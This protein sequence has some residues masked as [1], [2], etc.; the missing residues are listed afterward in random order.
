MDNYEILGISKDTSM[1]EVK[2]AYEERLYEI[3]NEVVN[4]KNAKAFKKVLKYAYEDIN[5]KSSIEDTLVMTKEDFRNAMKQAG[6]KDI[7]EEDDYYEDDCDEYTE[8]DYNYYYGED[9]S[10]N[11]EE[12]SYEDE[13]DYRI[14]EVPRQRRSSRYSKK[15]KHKNKKKAK[16]NNTRT[17]EYDR[18]RSEI[19][20]DEEDIE[21]NKM[22]WLIKFPLSVLAIPFIVVLAI[23]LFI[24]DILNVIL[25]IIAK[26]LIFASVVGG[27][28]YGLAVYKE[29]L[30][31]D[32]RA[33]VICGV[34]FILSLIVP[35]VLE[36]I[37][38]PLEILNNKLK[39]FVF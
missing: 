17:R 35:P 30:P 23:I 9:N 4:R 36:V 31:L 7:D 3:D 33:F 24:C 11:Q 8:E 6:F 39:A 16:K 29:M 18:R 38:K 27:V 34:V 2:A 32:N 28:A 25:S 14:N 10:D 20:R 13:S 1:E 22:P 37:F 12:S 5:N 19:Y 15:N 26:L 21:D